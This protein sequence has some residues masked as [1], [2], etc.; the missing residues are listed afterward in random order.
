[1][2]SKA[3]NDDRDVRELI[4]L[5]GRREPISAE[6]T[7]RVRN[8]A[9]SEWIAHLQSKTTRRRRRSR[10]LLMAAALVALAV[11]GWWTKERVARSSERLGVVEIV[12]GSIDLR[13]PEGGRIARLREGSDI[14]T[15]N[16]VAVPPDGRLA[17]RA[18]SGHSLRA[19]GDTRFRVVSAERI[20][21][22]RGTIYVDSGTEERDPD[23]AVLEI[24]TRLG[25]VHE[26]G[27]QYEVQLTERALRLRVRRGRI[28]WRAGSSR[29]EGGAGEQLVVFPDGSVERAAVSTSG[30]AW[31][32][33][34]SVTPIPSFDGRPAAAFLEWAAREHGV[35]LRY[36]S[37]AARSRAEESRFAG[38]LSGLSPTESLAAVLR[39][40]ELRKEAAG[41]VW[42]IE[43]EP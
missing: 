24:T 31:E 39:A 1:M 34:E 33:L 7:A 38:S 12:H 17:L 18:G 21:L 28:A 43:V 37:D 23:R 19:D 41:N 20:E 29:L 16:H 5:A 3:P 25:D 32:W 11:A 35:D 36:E 27:T 6:R 14:E 15:G 4:R 22:E 40:T 9:R 2:N 13:N 30:S 8:A 26:V 10:L 42:T